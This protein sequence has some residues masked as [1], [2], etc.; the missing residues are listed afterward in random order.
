MIKK[1]ILITS[2][3]LF[4]SNCGF[5]PIYL[6]NENID[7]SIEQINYVGDRE[8]NNFLK[9]NLYQYKNETVDN[10]IFIEANSV[11]KK[12]ILSNGRLQIFKFNLKKGELPLWVDVKFENRTKLYDFL[13]K[14]KI[15][16]RFFWKPLNLTLPYKQSFKKLKY[17]ERMKNK[18]MWLPSSLNM[19][20]SDINYVCEQINKFFKDPS[21]FYKKE[22]I[23]RKNINKFSINKN[24]NLFKNLF[25]RI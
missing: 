2:I 9:T 22:I 6:N 15:S 1:N 4:L 7:F 13:K 25:N 23:C 5:A 8:L 10:K 19:N 12:N 24:I 21:T 20:K 16:C 14:R 18:L 17:S 11:Y 3:I